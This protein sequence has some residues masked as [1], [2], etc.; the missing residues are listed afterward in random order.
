MTKRQSA[1]RK[2]ARRI[3]VRQDALDDASQEK[4]RRKGGKL[5][6]RKRGGIAAGKKPS[7]R[8][9][10]PRRS[11]GG[12]IQVEPLPPPPRGNIPGTDIPDLGRSEDATRG[13]RFDHTETPNNTEIRRFPYFDTDRRIW[14]EPPDPSPS[15]AP[16]R[17]TPG[18]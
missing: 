6:K 7:F 1:R 8:A 3:V 13:S 14:R 4:G 5:G 2:S 18:C 9:D 12:S 15:V 11:D 10:K 17:K 16:P